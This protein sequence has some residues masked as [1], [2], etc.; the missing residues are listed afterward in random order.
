MGVGGDLR[1]VSPGE[2]DDC[3]PFFEAQRISD[4]GST[5]ARTSRRTQRSTESA[6]E[7]TCRSSPTQ[8]RAQRREAIARQA[9]LEPGDPIL[10]AIEAVP[11]ERFVPV[12]AID[13]STRD[14]AVPLDDSGQAT[15][16]AMHAYAVAYRLLGVEPGDRVTEGPVSPARSPSLPLS[17][18]GPRRRGVGRGWARRA[19]AVAVAGALGLGCGVTPDPTIADEFH[20]RLAPAGGRGWARVPCRNRARK[21][22]RT[23]ALV[24]MAQDLRAHLREPDDPLPF[25]LHERIERHPIAGLAR[26]YRCVVQDFVRI[27]LDTEPDH[28]LVRDLVAEIYALRGRHLLEE[29]RADEGWAR[30]LEAIELFRA[31]VAPGLGQHFTLLGVLRITGR[32]LDTHPPPP[33]V[34][35]A[36]VAALDDTAVPRR[37][38]CASLRHDLLTLGALDFRVHFGQ[39][40]REA[41]A[42]RFG[43]DLAMRTWRTPQRPGMLRRAEWEALR[44]AYDRMVDGCAQRAYGHTLQRA[45]APLVRMD[46][47]HPPT[48]VDLRLA[49]NQLNRLAVLTDARMSMLAR[50]RGRLLRH[51][52]GRDPTTAELALSFGRRPRNAWD[53]RPYTFVVHE[54]RITIS[55]GPYHHAVPIDPVVP[56]PT[57]RSY[58][59]G[60]MASR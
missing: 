33:E 16:S 10:D 26:D 59:E 19:V 49:A 36:L 44:D 3:S 9:Q 32:L 25:E 24:A 30:V 52:L 41:F 5:S 45:A 56:P 1:A 22:E 48:G 37:L 51:T 21:I 57:G 13:A 39:R 11:R 23:Q 53:L 55:R 18:R 50:L 46:G 35:T 15:V 12:E 38:A 2:G 7:S 8:L 17:P 6:Y 28:E 20:E 4:P 42:R 58:A 43:L 14:Q 29:G 31:P 27:D 54:G 47:L 60:A 34:L 40:E